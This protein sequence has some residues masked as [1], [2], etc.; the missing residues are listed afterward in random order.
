MRKGEANLEL[1]RGSKAE[2][3]GRVSY[4]RPFKGITGRR[5]TSGYRSQ[6]LLPRV[7]SQLRVGES[8]AV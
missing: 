7:G 2:R 3:R 4:H 5:E 6:S 8:W 1:E